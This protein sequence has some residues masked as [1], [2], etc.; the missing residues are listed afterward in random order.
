M[1]SILAYLTA[2]GLVHA[3]PLVLSY[4][5]DTLS[6]RA[7]GF[8]SVLCLNRQNSCLLSVNFASADMHVVC[9]KKGDIQSVIC[10][11]YGV[12]N[13]LYS[14]TLSTSE[15]QHIGWKYFGA[16]SSLTYPSVAENDLECLPSE[17][18]DGERYMKA[19]LYNTI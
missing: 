17:M 1:A 8:D 16:H 5:R 7:T 6:L 13:I 14:G 4:A 19:K 12:G 10:L 18:A 2:A 11:A 15:R 9:C 3:F